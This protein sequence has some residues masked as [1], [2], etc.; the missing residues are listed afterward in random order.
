MKQHCRGMLDDNTAHGASEVL[1]FP[2]G[3]VW[4]HLV[5]PAVRYMGLGTYES[6][7]V[8]RATWLPGCLLSFSPPAPM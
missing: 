7:V 1:E 6:Y 8:P 5:T 3:C 2:G 4:V